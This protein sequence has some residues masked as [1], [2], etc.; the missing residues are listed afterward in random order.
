M[1]QA[2]AA[3]APPPDIVL[4]GEVHDNAAH[5]RGQ[6][7]LLA[8]LSPAAVVF[9]MLGPEQ[10]AR[11]TPEARGDVGA[12]GALLDWE[13]SGW[14]DFALY[15]PVFE[16]LGRAAVFGAA[17]PAERVRAAF[18]AGA[19]ATFGPG[20]AA[21]GLAEALP[22]PERAARIE[23]QFAAHCEA[24][25]RDMMPGMIE[26][27]RLRDAAFAATALQ[28]L[29]VTGGPVAVIAGSGHARTDWGMPA[30]LRRARPDARV[31]SIGFAE[32]GSPTPPFDVTIVT[33]PAERGD[34]CAAFR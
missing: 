21:F 3:L 18:D 33:E 20:A 9:E 34:P 1:A 2:M 25:P 4:L 28:A 13:A 15:R 5:H 19:A 14:P 22:A 8:A 11:L 24:L 29:D 16:A 32:A 23:L 26:A 17:L 30:M 6:A 27:Q 12:L 7:E 31:L 10:A